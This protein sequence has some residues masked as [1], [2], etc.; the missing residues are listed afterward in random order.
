M[1][2]FWPFQLFFCLPLCTA[3]QRMTNIQHIVLFSQANI[4]LYTA[5]CLIRDAHTGSR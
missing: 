4:L 1:H 2:L 5:A 3:E